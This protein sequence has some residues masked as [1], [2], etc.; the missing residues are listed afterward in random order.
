MKEI[1]FL[2][3]V[4]K[5]KIWGGSR[6]GEHSGSA[7]GRYGIGECWAVSARQDGDCMVTGGSCHGKTLSWMWSE[8]RELFGNLP[9][10]AFPI[11]VKLIDADDD[12]SIQVH[13]D[14][15]YARTHEN[16][17]SGK[18]ECWFI[19]DCD[20]DARIA[21]G[22]NAGSREELVEMVQKGEWD[23]LIREVPVRKGDFFQI[24]PGTVHA[25]QRH[26]MLLEIQQNSDI[27]YRLYDYGRLQDGSPRSLD[28][29]KGLEVIACPYDAAAE[30]VR[31]EGCCRTGPEDG[32]ETYLI[33]CKYYQV[34]LIR[35]QGV[36][37]YFQG[38]PFAVFCVVGG[39]GRLDGT[40]VKKGEHF[41]LPSGYGKYT[42]Y[43]KL[44][45][46]KIVMPQ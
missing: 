36:R 17:A 35:V 46:I 20:E 32:S 45:L 43:G 38:D 33:R 21:I 41:I 12:L 24:E 40:A 28:L 9:G 39:E 34:S 44:Q 10:D 2:Q 16:G 29:E 27:T 6:L 8:R 31:K 1:I 19:L 5:E 3:G 11:L 14:D 25:I 26:T 13:P 37:S 18:T 15:E 4:F 23:K 7:A 22:H 42:F 30:P